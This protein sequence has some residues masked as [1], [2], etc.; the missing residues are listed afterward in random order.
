[1][2]KKIINAAAIIIGLSTA[3]AVIYYHLPQPATPFLNEKVLVFDEKRDTQAILDIF[4]DDWYWLVSS[5]DY[6]PEFTLKNRA[7]NKDPRYFGRL[8]IRVLYD[9]DKFVGFIC[10]YM[11]NFFMGQI[12]FIDVKKEFRGKGFAQRLMKYA[13]ADLKNQGATMI[14]LVTRTSNLDAQR[15]Y[16]KLGFTVTLEEDGFVYFELRP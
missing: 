10:Y 9:Q 13:I 14:N 7:P 1:M 6:S 5:D 12:L 8:S 4:K 3:G 16:K 15:V 2:R 11:K